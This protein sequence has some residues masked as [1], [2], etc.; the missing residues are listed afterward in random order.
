MWLTFGT[1]STTTT[2]W[3][4][5]IWQLQRRRN[6]VEKKEHKCSDSKLFRDIWLKGSFFYS[7]KSPMYPKINICRQSR[8]TCFAQ[9][10]RSQQSKVVGILESY[11][12]WSFRIRRRSKILLCKS[13]AQ[14]WFYQQS[15]HKAYDK[16]TTFIQFNKNFQVK[17]KT[18]RMY[19]S[20]LFWQ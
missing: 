15:E 1:E 8:W 5:A 3:R 4:M 14:F 6:Q 19:F 17:Q 7:C 18:I 9:R 11:V 16:Y 12:N 10:I 20:R 2:D 13:D